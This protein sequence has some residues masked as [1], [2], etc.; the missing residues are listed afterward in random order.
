MKKN[1]REILFL[2]LQGI[3]LLPI[4]NQIFNSEIIEIL[5][6]NKGISINSL[7][8]KINLNPGY[9]NVAFRSLKSSDLLYDNSNENEFDRKYFATKSLNKLYSYKQKIDF[10]SSILYFHNLFTS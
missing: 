8:E 5:K 4:L 6:L 10:F 3:V 1:Y 9:I 7:S 2:H